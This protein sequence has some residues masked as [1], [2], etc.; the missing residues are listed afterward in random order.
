MRPLVCVMILASVAAGCAPVQISVQP[1]APSAI[2]TATTSATPVRWNVR[3]G[4]VIYANDLSD[5]RD[6]LQL[7]ET[8]E[9]LPT[10]VDGGLSLQLKGNSS[11]GVYLPIASPRTHQRVEAEVVFTN[12]RGSAGIVCRW[13]PTPTGIAEY[14]IGVQ[15]DGHYGIVRVHTDGTVF[16]RLVASDV[17]SVAIANRGKNHVE[18]ECVGTYPVRLTLRVNGVT[19]AEVEDSRGGALETASGAGITLSA[20]DQPP[21]A[22]IFSNLVVRELIV[23]R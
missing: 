9:V 20:I 7:K 23:E 3:E 19:L 11:V 21:V 13:I 6:E 18:A 1:A 5:P 8:A 2:A 17:P 12:G 10:Y 22:A 15:A 14:V 16:E 4:A